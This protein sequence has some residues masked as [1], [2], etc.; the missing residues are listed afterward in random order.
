MMDH[1]ARIEVLDQELAA[2]HVRIR[3]LEDALG[4]N[5]PAPL[6][7]G[8][9]PKQ[10]RVL[11]VLMKR[12]V[13]TKETI[14]AA[15]YGHISCDREIPGQKIVDVFI[16]HMRKKLATFGIQIKTVWGDGY[17]LSNGDKEKINHIVGQ[18]HGKVAA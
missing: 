3:E 9:T 14:V 5:Y 15:L 16:C 17:A 4:V 8:L 12:N 13:A 6:S 10:A 18:E 7:F 1:Q 2:A 11:G